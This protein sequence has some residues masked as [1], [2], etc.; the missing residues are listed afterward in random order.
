MTKRFILIASFVVQ[1]LLIGQLWAT[2]DVTIYRTTD[3]DAPWH[4]IRLQQDSHGLIWIGSWNGLYRFDGYHFQ[5]FKPEPGQGCEI[6]NDRIRDIMMAGGDSLLCRFDEGIYVFDIGRCL[7]SSLPDSL[8]ADFEQR[9]NLANDNWTARPIEI[10]GQTYPDIQQVF[11]DQQGNQ[12]LKGIDRI[13][14]LHPN[15]R[16]G[17]MIEGSESLSMPRRLYR[18]SEGCYWVCSRDNQQV[19]LFDSEWK[20]IG[21]LGTDGSLHDR[22]TAFAPIYCVFDNGHGTIWLGSKPD[23]LYRLTRRGGNQFRVER[24]PV[25]KSQQG[26][27]SNAIYDIQEDKLGTLWLA[28]WDEGVICLDNPNEPDVNALHYI[29]MAEHCPQYPTEALKTRRIVIRPD[30][31]MLVTSTRGLLIIENIYTSP[32]QFVMHLHRREANR[33]ESLSSSA[34]MA[35]A[36]DKDDYLY[37]ATESGGINVATT[38]D[39]HVDRLEFR[40][41]T[42]REGLTSDVILELTDTPTSYMLAVSPNGISAIDLKNNNIESYGRQFWNVSAPFIECVPQIIGDSMLILVHEAGIIRQPLRELTHHEYVPYI[43]LT[44]VSIASEPTRYDIDRCDTLRL[45]SR[46][47]SLTLNYAAIDLRSNLSLR[48]RTRLTPEGQ[49]PGDWSHASDVHQVQLQDLRPGQYQLQIWS[50]NA[51]GQ[52][53]DNVRTVTIIVEPRFFEAWYGQLL[54]WLVFAIIVASI[55]SM[56]INMRRIDNKRHELLQTYLTLLESTTKAKIASAASRTSERNLANAVANGEVHTAHATQASAI[57]QTTDDV[58]DEDATLAASGSSTSPIIA[59]SMTR[60]SVLDQ[61]FMQ[62]LIDYVE[63]NI[64]NS[65]ASLADMAEATATSKSSLTRKTHQL[66]G[67]TP[68]DFLK[69]ARLKRASQLLLTTTQSLSEIALA[70]GF[71]DPKYFS[72]CFKASTGKTPTEYRS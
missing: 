39:L 52:W 19:V 17:T 57:A 50:S 31:T 56:A 71:S 3:E 1:L 36:F 14:C 68:A 61:Q 62:R 11:T 10:D 58:T 47:R 26:L 23:G 13:Y 20:R 32:S 64:G 34:A 38:T 66:L 9:M 21:Y 72:K 40:H 53:G 2:S 55:T 4:P 43:A 69:E 48:Y 24:I 6:D 27:P 12:W 18:D 35:L 44:E 45:T 25:S 42:A 22:P 15:Q 46:Q 59:G 33:R 67:V 70:C 8:Q 7:F 51:Y 49:T 63:Q 65:D 41:I 30:G 28:S 54:L 37:V 5:S 16:H 29:S 60:L